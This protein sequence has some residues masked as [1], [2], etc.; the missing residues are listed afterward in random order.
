MVQQINKFFKS[1]S[2]DLQPLPDDLIPAEYPNLPN[3][4]VISVSDVE[5][6]LSNINIWK[7]PGPDQLPNWV[8]RDMAE[9]LAGPVCAIFNASLREGHFP[10]LWKKA[11]VIPVPKTRPLVSIE[12]DLRPI[13]LIST[14]GKQLEALV[15]R[16]ILERVGPQLDKRQFGA[17]KGRSTVH[18]LTDML[19]VW[20]KALDQRQSVRILFIDYSK[21][22]HLMAIQ[23]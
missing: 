23:V 7:A 22:W 20:H 21:A 5:R 6:R 18:I 19:H 11:N 9:L 12:N 4:F 17:L 15:V 2:S 3:E 16:Q 8:L 14:L 10:S 13:S 1:V